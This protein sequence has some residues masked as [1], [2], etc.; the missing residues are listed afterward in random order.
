MSQLTPQPRITVQPVVGRPL[1]PSRAAR[2][3]MG[4]RAWRRS[5]PFWG[6]LLC[7]LGGLVI[8]AGPLSAIQI[9][10][11]SGQAVWLG[12]LVGALVVVMGAFAWGNP[13]LRQI[14]GI[15][16]VIFS[17]VSLITSDYGGFGL[18]LT[19]GIVGGALTFAWTP[20]QPPGPDSPP[21][22]PASR[23]E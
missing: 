14:C 4:F 10:L 17:L 3:R 11:I 20:L 13:A 16:A 15:L 6:G 8:A 23:A 1:P 7:I 5:R 19:L 18:G 2:V 21:P 22:S 12:I 9:V